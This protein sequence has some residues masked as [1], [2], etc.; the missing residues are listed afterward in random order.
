MSTRFAYSFPK[1]EIRSKMEQL[2]RLQSL[3]SDKQQEI[4]EL[5]G[6]LMASKVNFFFNSIFFFFVLNYLFTHYS[7]SLVIILSGN[8]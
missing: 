1:A 8:E 4:D 6:S 2:D 5:T 3:N 7:R